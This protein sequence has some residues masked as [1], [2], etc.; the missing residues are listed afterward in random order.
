MSDRQMMSSS[1]PSSWVVPS[2]RTIVLPFFLACAAFLLLYSRSL[3]GPVIFYDDFQF[4]TQSWTW[5]RT[6]DGL[7]APQNEH[8]MPL[9]RLFCFGLEWLA[10]RLTRL[11]FLTCWVGPLALLLA[12]LLLYVFVRR[13]Q[14]HPFYAVLVV[15]LFGVTTVY[16]QSV[17]WFAATFA[18]LALDTMLLGLLAAQRWR[19]SGARLDLLLCV[20]ACLLAPGW[21]TL[22]ILAG[23]LCCLYLLSPG[24]GRA[25][26][27]ATWLASVLPL[28]GTASFLAISL[29]R[30]AQAILHTS[31]YGEQTAVEAF[32]P[33]VGLQYT[34]RS[35]VDN[36][37]L[38]LLG[39]AGVALPWWSTAAVL[40][41]VVAAAVWW[42][43]RAREHRLM[44]LGLALIGA[45]Y[46][47]SYSARAL[48]DYQR[49]VEP[50][51][52]RYHLLSHLGLVLFFCG[53]LPAWA[54]RWF[55]LDAAEAIAARQRRFLYGLIGVCFLV[56]LPRGLLCG[57][58]TGWDQFAEM[59]AQ[60]AALSHIEE[61]EVRCRR[62]RISAAAARQTLGRL[63]VPLSMDV[64]DGWEFLIGS[65]DPRPRPIEEV[66][67]LLDNAE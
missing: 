48:W 37:L 63:N 6:C 34:A 30:T 60:Q 36:L 64:I 40:S 20:L 4:L 56:Q 59:A 11:P 62:Y 55:T 10:G 24:T 33:L 39:V 53:G 49:M 50:A 14:G 42:W 29:P 58:P 2:R 31:H 1:S 23:P 8:A 12:L 67:R 41:A 19:R 21:F 27:G 65:D 57:S 7:W 9:G 22:G 5:Q 45:N 28:A 25:R 46:W 38:G 26:T 52:A 66:R 15:V 47:L 44:L 61:V 43:R 35:L 13:E 16:H 18:I 17:W 54:G 3:V 51:F 32:Q